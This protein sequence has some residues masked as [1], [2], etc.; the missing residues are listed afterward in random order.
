VVHLV[1]GIGRLARFERMQRGGAEQDFLVLEF[2]DAVN[3]FV[4]AAKI[5]LVQKYVGGRGATPDLSEVGSVA[6]QDGRKPPRKP[7]TT[8]PRT[9]STSRRCAPAR[10]ASP[11]PRTALGRRPSRRRSPTP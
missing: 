5:D 3:V 2:A 6:W 10:R 11:I 8:S 1:H 9:S 4:P 7:P